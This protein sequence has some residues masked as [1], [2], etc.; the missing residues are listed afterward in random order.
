VVTRSG[1]CCRSQGVTGFLVAAARS[2]A[3]LDGDLGRPSRGFGRAEL[4]VLCRLAGGSSRGRNNMQLSVACFLLRCY[5]RLQLQ[6]GCE[7]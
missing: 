3:D 7:R 5:R 4:G 2:P 1:S 6:G